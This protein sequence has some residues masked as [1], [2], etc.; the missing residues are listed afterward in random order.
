V[1]EGIETRDF[2]IAAARLRQR[3]EGLHDGQ[4]QNSLLD[5]RSVTQKRGRLSSRF[6]RSKIISSFF[7][8]Q[9]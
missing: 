5:R 9:Y 1:A 2:V 6:N 8:R 4:I 7:L 3:L